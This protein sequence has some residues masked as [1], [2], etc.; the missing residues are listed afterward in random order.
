[1]ADS[2]TRPEWDPSAAAHLADYQEVAWMV[3]LELVP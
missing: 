1:L 3:W 2:L